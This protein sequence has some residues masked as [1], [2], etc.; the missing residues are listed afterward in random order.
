MQRVI[1][2]IESADWRINSVAHL[3]DRVCVGRCYSYSNYEP[4]TAQFR[5]RADRPNAIVVTGAGDSFDIERGSY[6]VKERDLPLYQLVLD[7]AGAGS[8]TAAKNRRTF[9]RYSVARVLMNPGPRRIMAGSGG[10]GGSGGGSG[11]FGGRLSRR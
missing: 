10:G 7:D 4:S 1:S 3:I 2:G 11:F 5:V 8:D 9:R 6:V